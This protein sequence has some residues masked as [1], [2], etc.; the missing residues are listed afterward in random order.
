M[1]GVISIIRLAASLRAIRYLIINEGATTVVI[2]LDDS[3]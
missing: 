1:V 3:T 2:I